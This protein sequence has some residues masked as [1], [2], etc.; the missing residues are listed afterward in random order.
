[1]SVFLKSL[2]RD[3]HLAI[4]N[5]F[6]EPETFDEVSLKSYE[7][8]AKATYALMQ[9]LNDDDLSRVIYCKSAYEIWASLITTHEGTDQVKKC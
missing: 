1:M 6:K 8:N 5:E 9:A 3:I 7:A 4:E 2:G